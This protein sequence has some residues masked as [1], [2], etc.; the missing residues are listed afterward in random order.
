VVLLVLSAMCSAVGARAEDD[1]QYTGLDAATV[2]VFVFSGV[3]LERV[4]GVRGAYVMGVPDAGHGSGLLVTRDGLILTARHVIEDARIIAVQF[5]GEEAVPA[6]V[7][8]S[9]KERDHAFLAVTGQRKNFVPIPDH[10]LKLAVRQTVFVIGYPLDASRTHPQSQQGIVSGVLPDGSLQLGVALNPG[11]SGGPVVD[12]EERLLGIAVARADPAA[13]AQGIGVAVPLEQLRPA[14]EQLRKGPELKAARKELTSQASRLDADAALLATLLTADD[15]DN[16][17]EALTG[18]SG[19]PS[20]PSVDQRLDKAFKAGGGPTADV[21]ALAAAQQWNAAAV[22]LDRRGSADTALALAKQLAEQAK[23]ADSE[24]VKR[25]PL[26]AFVL[27]GH[28]PS[29]VGADL[30]EGEAAR[31]TNEGPGDPKQVLMRSLETSKS[32]P[33]VRIGPT[34]GIITPF[35]LVGVGVLAKFMFADV[36]SLNAR[37]QYGWHIADTDRTGAHYFQALGGIAVG[38]WR[39]STTAQLVVDVENTGWATIFHYVP[40]KVPTIHSLVVEAGV[41]SGPV[42]ISSPTVL[43]STSVRQAFVL[44][45]GLRYTHFYHATSPYL[46]RSVREV[47]ELSAHALA[48]PLGLPDN[49]QNADGKDIKPLPGFDFDVAWETSFSLGQSEL[50]AGYYPG[51]D[52]IYFHLG[53]SY[54]FY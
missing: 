54:L 2:R 4:R 41:Q 1:L 33:V 30:P 49:A 26:I 45:G 14:Y 7:V 43:G 23:E 40:G 3:K 20:S 28:Q 35:Q 27:D 21:L 12:S 19:G 32:L 5:P 53:W 34:I 50:G 11:N 52:W 39:R 10:K 38:T 6:R 31:T 22:A 24:V 42:N 13:G 25:S 36:V 48:P 18:K 37:Y 9:D 8:Y 16:A 47:L 17:Y 15:A 51:S 46:A 44:E 29:D